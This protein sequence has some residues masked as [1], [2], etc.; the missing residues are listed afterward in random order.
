MGEV[1]VELTLNNALD[2]SRS[3]T[4][5]ALA[6]TG[7]MLSMLPMEL[8]QALGLMLGRCA[9]VRLADGR[10]QQVPVALGVR[11]DID[12]RVTSDEALLLGDQVRVGWVVLAKLHLMVDCAGRRLVPDPSQPEYPIYRV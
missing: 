3:R 6:D 1:V 2:P 5:A 10:T 7:A 9:G 4:V 8:A 11:F 12:G